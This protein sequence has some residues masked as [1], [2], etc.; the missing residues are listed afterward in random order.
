MFTLEIAISS[1]TGEIIDPAAAVGFNP[2][3][4]PP[5]SWRYAFDP[6][7]AN[8]AHSVALFVPLTGGAGAPGST[9]ITYSF[10]VLD[11]FDTPLPI[12]L[13]ASALPALGGFAQAALVCLLLA[14]GIWARRM[15]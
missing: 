4:E 10:Q 14:A 2:Q 3:P 7:P 8:P 6:A 11:D 1:T 5:A 15:V 9:Q 12:S 13:V